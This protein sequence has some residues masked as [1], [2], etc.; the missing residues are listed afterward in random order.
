MICFIYLIDVALFLF[1]IE[2]YILKWLVLYHIVN[3]VK[4]CKF[5]IPIDT[6]IVEKKAKPG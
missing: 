2:I 6:E 3:N 1:E 5:Y 4:N